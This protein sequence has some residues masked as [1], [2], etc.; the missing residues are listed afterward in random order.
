MPA[1]LWVIF[2]FDDNGWSVMGVFT[3]RESALTYA[4][5]GEKCVPF[6]ADTRLPDDLTNYIEG[7]FEVLSKWLT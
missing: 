7:E 3:S 6:K 4:K 1:E 5:T 2:R